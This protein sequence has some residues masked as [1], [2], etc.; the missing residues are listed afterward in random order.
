M[1][2]ALV[3]EKDDCGLT[4]VSCYPEIRDAARAL[5]ARA[6]DSPESK[7]GL[8]YTI[9]AGLDAV[10]TLGDGDF[11]LFVVADQPW[12][13]AK[14]VSRLLGRAQPGVEA[15]CAAYDGRMGNPMLFSAALAPELW[16]LTGDHGGR[17]VAHR[18]LCE[19]VQVDDPRELCDVDAPEDM[20]P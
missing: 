12:L 2:S 18:H 7:K 8:S 11:L 20:I 9:R 5:G 4:V 6:A 1:L 15:A 17:G 10:G 19:T 16:E 3:S 13:T 14:T